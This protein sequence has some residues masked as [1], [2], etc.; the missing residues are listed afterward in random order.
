[1]YYEVG[2]VPGTEKNRYNH[3]NGRNIS[4][5]GNFSQMSLVFCLFCTKLLMLHSKHPSLIFQ[6]FFSS[7]LCAVKNFKEL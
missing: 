4:P 6:I 3:G 5:N 1:M 7:P 2:T